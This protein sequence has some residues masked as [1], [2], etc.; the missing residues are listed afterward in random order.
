M[1][2]MYIFMYYVVVIFLIL[3]YDFKIMLKMIEM[4]DMIY[5]F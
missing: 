2:N 4:I 1:Y 3:C 5:L